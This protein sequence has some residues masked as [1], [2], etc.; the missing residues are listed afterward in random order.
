MKVSKLLTIASL[1]LCAQSATA[2]TINVSFT[3]TDAGKSL[4]ID[5]GM[6]TA[7]DDEYNVRWGVAHYG[8]Q[9]QTGR[10]SFQPYEP[11]D[12]SKID[13]ASAN[14]GLPLKMARKLQQR[15]DRIKLTGTT[16]VN[17]NCDHEVLTRKLD[18][19][20]NYGNAEDFV[21]KGNF[22]STSKNLDQTY[23]DRWKDLIKASVKYAQKQGLEV[24][25]VSPFNEPDYGWNQFYNGN[26]GVNVTNQFTYGMRDFLAIAQSIRNDDFFATGA[27]KDVRICGPNTLNCD[28]ALPWYNYTG[29][30]AV[31]QEGN[32][33]QLAGSFKG[34]ADF[35]T[36]MRQDG[37]VA[38]GDELHN[39]GE[40]IVGVEY[41]MQNGIWWAFDAKARGQFMHD[42]NEGVRIGYAEDRNHWTSAAVYRNE[43][44]GEIH[45]FIGSSER[46]A[47][48]STYK[49]Q[50]KD[51][52]VFFNGY[53]PLKE[54]TVTTVG[55]TG[56]QQGQINY[57]YLFDITFGEDVQQHAVDGEYQIMS[58]ADLKLITTA[59]YGN[60]VSAARQNNR[61][62]QRWHI[63]PDNLRK[64]GDCSYWFIDNVG[65]G[66]QHLN[67]RA[68]NL[69]AGTKVLTY[70]ASHDALEQW[71]FRYAKDG[72][73]YIIS[74]Q[75]NKYIYNNGGTVSVE[76]EPTDRTS[77]DELKKYMWRLLPSEAPAKINT[78]AMPNGLKAGEASANAVSMSWNASEEANTTYTVLR[79][80]ENGWN[81]VARQLSEP[82]FTDVNVTRGKSYNY[83]VMAV[84]YSQNRS[85]TSPSINIIVPKT[86]GSVPTDDFSS[87]VKPT[88]IAQKGEQEVLLPNGLYRMTAETQL[89]EQGEAK[90]YVE[91]YRSYEAD[92]TAN[93]SN[94]E[95]AIDNILVTNNIMK[96]GIKTLD[97][98]DN[99]KAENFTLTRISKTEETALN[100]YT[101]A[102]V[103]LDEQTDIELLRYLNHDELVAARTAA[104]NCQ[105]SQT[106]YEPVI[107]NY[108]DALRRAQMSKE[109]APVVGDDFSSLIPDSWTKSTGNYGDA[110]ERSSRNTPFYS[111]RNLYQT[112]SDLI[113]GARYQVDFYAVAN[114][115]DLDPSLY[116]GNGIAYVFA[117]DE[118]EDITVFNQTSCNV[119]NYPHSLTCTASDRGKIVY[120]IGNR[121]PGGQWYVAKAKSLTFVGYEHTANLSCE[122]GQYSTFVA[123]FDITL[124]DGIKAFTIGGTDGSALKLLDASENNMLEAN[125]PVIIYNSTQELI[126]QSYTGNISSLI[127]ITD[128]CLTGLLQTGRIL[129]FNAFVMQTQDNV[130]S[131]FYISEPTY[132]TANR[133][134]LNKNASTMNTETQVFNLPVQGTSISD[135]PGTAKH[136]TNNILYDLSGRKIARPISN[137]NLKKGIYIIDGKKIIK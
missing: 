80:D 29:M 9:F 137:R 40:A 125:K 45:G 132:S 99:V 93:E 4:P 62:T 55:G 16:R 35:F 8:P 123:P 30:S 122:P 38:T 131:F 85:A 41:G 82:S 24:V 106:A 49:F 1:M 65:D 50:C 21:G 63:Y 42:S 133:C 83:K 72:Y 102:V 116:S 107:N 74:R 134:Y 66:T 73:F 119:E 46:Q 124:P 117:N 130:Q 92:I 10:I 100:Y 44:D 15:I 98:T 79:L 70:N 111:G 22:V 48:V 33:H 105:Q 112:I 127:D 69:D 17:I 58:A 59:G 64:A 71:Y 110:A 47:N 103:Y 34:Y 56:Y 113:P 13:N 120:G 36:K 101:D 126:E 11:V 118:E 32:T 136:K 3:T 43:K 96:I 27:G 18:E 87:F 95:T 77:E 25:S 12:V 2:Q 39:V 61:N 51:R 7:W 84:D 81:T 121:K 94:N 28:R 14:F 129:P 75:S 89:S 114:N 128:G 108:A 54:W 31:I 67:L 60:D 97:N 88:I 6:D 57:E 53:G 76:S 115:R 91:T 26:L 68:G 90:L 135:L 104:H 109:T 23:I 78:P 19:N 86:D 37:K 20:G 52:Y 5:W